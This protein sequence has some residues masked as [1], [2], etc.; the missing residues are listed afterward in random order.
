M[1]FKLYLDPGNNITT[2]FGDR[3]KLNVLGGT[4]SSQQ[5]GY[6]LG[7]GNGGA[8]FSAEQLQLPEI[9]AL[10]RQDFT[11]SGVVSGSVPVQLTAGILTVTDAALAAEKPG[12]FVR[13]QPDQS[14]SALAEQNSGLSVVL[15]AMNNFQYHT[16]TAAVDYSADGLMTA[17]TSI[18]GANPQ[19]QEGR[20]VYLNLNLEENIKKLLESLRLGTDVAEKIGEKTTGRPND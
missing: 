1:G 18:K 7:T 13:Y 20:E 5:F 4:I 14:V 15:A 2:L 12:G 10:Q 11:C 3:L 19:Y 17:R 16:L 9:L 8:M 6:D